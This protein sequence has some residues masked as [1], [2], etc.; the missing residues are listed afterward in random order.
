MTEEEYSNAFAVKCSIPV[1]DFQIWATVQAESVMYGL[2]IEFD[3]QVHNY[4][5]DTL[6][7]NIFIGRLLGWPPQAF[8]DDSLC[9]LLI[10]PDTTCL[11]SWDTVGTATRFFTFWLRDTLNQHLSFFNKWI[12]VIQ[13]RA[14]V[15]VSC[16]STHYRHNDT[17]NYEVEFET[18][19][20]G[21][22]SFSVCIYHEYAWNVYDTIFELR[23]TITYSRDSTVSYYSSLFLAQN[24]P[25]GNYRIISETFWRGKKAGTG[26][27][28]FNLAGP[29][30]ALTINKDKAI[31]GQ[32]TVSFIFSVDP[33]SYICENNKLVYY[34]SAWQHPVEDTLIMHEIQYDTL[35]N[36]DTLYAPFALDLD[37]ITLKTQQYFFRYGLSSLDTINGYYLFDH[38]FEL[39]MRG[40]F[41]WKRWADTVSWEIGLKNMGDFIT[42]VWLVTEF[43]KP[44]GNF[45]DSVQI[46]LALDTDT[47]IYCQTIID[48]GTPTGY[49]DVATRVWSGIDYKEIKRLCHIVEPLPPNILIT[50]DTSNY[51]VGDTVTVI[52]YNAGELEGDV[53][54][55]NIALYDLDWNSFPLDTARFLIS[56][57]DFAFYKFAVPEVMSGPYHLYIMGNVEIYNIPIEQRVD[58]GID[59]IEADITLLTTK[60]IY[61]PYEEVE[62]QAMCLNGNY[63]F[64]GSI[65]L[66]ITRYGLFPGDTT[67]A[68]GDEWVWRVDEWTS[69]GCTLSNNKVSLIG[70]DKLY[71]ADWWQL[72]PTEANG[73]ECSSQRVLLLKLLEAK[74]QGKGRGDEPIKYTAM[75][76]KDGELYMAMTTETRRKIAGPYPEWTQS[77]DLSEITSIYQFTMDD[78]Y[79]YITDVDS[80]YVYKV[81]RSSGSIEK[82]WRVSNPGGIGVLSGYL[83]T[84]DRVNHSVLKTNLSGDTILVFGT[85]S[86]AEPSDLAIDSL[87]KIYVADA[88]KARVY[89]FD[90]N[91][92]YLG[93]KGDGC[94]FS[95]IAVDKKGYLYGAD[96]D[97]M[98]VAKFDEN[99][100][101]V[102]Y[103][104]WGYP[105]EIM[106]CDTL[107]HLA[108]IYSG[109]F[110]YVAGN[111]LVNYGRNRGYSGTEFIYIPGLKYI[112]NFIA[113]DDPKSGA[114]EYYFSG[115][116]PNGIELPFMPID[117]L[118]YFDFETEYG[119]VVVRFRS[120]LS[121]P[122][123]GVSPEVEKLNFTY[124]SR[125]SGDIVWFDSESLSLAPL[126][127][128]LI[129]KNA[130]IISDSGEFA[131]WG[132]VC[133]ANGQNYPPVESH[134]FFIESALLSFALRIDKELY[135]PHEEITTSAIIVNNSD[136]TYT[137]IT[138]ELFKREHEVFDTL[139]SSIAPQSACTLSLVLSDSSS[140]LLTGLLF[141]PGLD[142]M[143][144]YKNVDI[145]IPEISFWSDYPCSVSHRSFEISTEL[146][147]W[148]QREVDIIFRSACG[149]SVYVDTISLQPNESRSIEHDFTI[150]QDES[151]FTEIIHP[152]LIKE[153]YPIRFGER[154][155][156]IIDSIVSSQNNIL[157][158]YET[159]NIG[160]FD[161]AFEMDLAITNT[162]GLVCD[163]MSCLNFLQ[164]DDSLQGEWGVSLDFGE[165][166]LNWTT[167]PESS[168]IILGQ[169]TTGI[170]IIQPNLVNVDS[171]VLQT[172]CDSIGD[173]LFDVHVKNNSANAFYGN[174]GLY[175]SFIGETR[176]LELAPFVSD[177]VRFTSSATLNKGFELVTAKIL[178]NGEA[179]SEYTDS[180]YF[181]SMLVIDSLPANLAFNIG[182]TARIC[183]KTE[184]N[185]TAVGEENLRFEFADFVDESRVV[186]LVPGE[187]R[188]DTFLFYLPE[189]LEEKTYYAS[190][191]LGSEEFV[192]PIYILGYKIIVNANLNQP[193]FLPGDTVIL[194]LN[195]ENQN[196]L[197]LKGF[198]V[199]N[200][201][202]ENLTQN[203]LLSGFIKNIDISNPEF[204]KATGDSGVYVSTILWPGNFDSLKITPQGSGTFGFYA[205]IVESD[206][207]HYSGWYDDSIITEQSQALQIKV[208]FSDT[209]ST[210]ERVDLRLFDSLTIRDTIIEQFYPVDL[211]HELFFLFEP[212][213]NLMFYGVYTESGRGLWLS[214]IHVFEANDTCNII[215]NNQVY[216]MG[217]TVYATVQSPFSGEL[218]WSSD[219]DPFGTIS[220]SLWIDS[221]SNQFEFI[222][223]G[224]LS[225]GQ[226]S[227]DFDFY[228]DGDTLQRFSATQSFD[229]RG[230]QVAVFDCRLDTNEYQVNDS[231]FIRFKLNSSKQIPLI[232]KL[233]FA[234]NY[235]WY[236]ALC[237]TIEVDSGYNV[238]DLAT[239]VVP[240]LERGPALLSYS[241]LK[242][243]IFLAYSSEGFMVYIPDSLAPIAQFV[244]I[245]ENTY[246]PNIDYT[247]R[248]VATDE[249]RIYDTL[250]YHN[251]ITQN[252][253]TYQTK[254]GDTLIYEIPSQPRGTNIAYYIVL[255]DS[256]GNLTRLPEIDYNQFWVLSP[257]PPSNCETDTINQNIE[258]SW[259]N[260]TENLIYHSG[261]PYEPKSDSI[262]VRFTPQYLPAELKAV[263]LFVEKTTPD[264]AAL[265]LGFYSVDQGIPGVELYPPQTIMVTEEGANWIDVPIDSGAIE[266]ELFVI[267]SGENIILYG[268]GT[269]NAYRTLIRDEIWTPDTSFGN[270]LAQAGFSY[271]PESTFYRV[272][273]E[274]TMQFIVIADSLTDKTFIDSTVS[275]ERRFRYLVQT[276]YIL[277]DLNGTSPILTQTYDYTSPIF[278][279]SITVVECASGYLVAC[280]IFDGIGVA[281][282]SLVYNGTPT[283]HDS[284]INDLYWYTVPIAGQTIAYYFTAEDSAG[285]TARN[286][287][288]GYFY[289]IP[290]IPE[291]FSGHISKDTTWAIDILIKGDVWVDSGVTLT[292][293][294]GVNVKFIPNIDDEHAGIDTTRAEFIIQGD[295]AL[296]GNDSTYVFFTS[297]VSQPEIGNWYGIRFENADSSI[298]LEYTEVE[299]AEIGLHCDLNKPFQVKYCKIEFCNTGVNSASK[300]TKITDSEF[301]NNQDGAVITDG[302]LNMVKRCD[303]INNLTALTI[304]GDREK[305][306]LS[307]YQNSKA[308]GEDIH[309]RIDPEYAVHV[310]DYRNKGQKVLVFDNLFSGNDTG[311]VFMDQAGA[312]VK[313]NEIIENLIGLFITDDACPNLG[314]AMSGENLFIARSDT[315]DS[316]KS[317]VV[318]NNTIND[319]LA[320][321]NWWGTNEEDSITAIIWDYYDDNMLGLVD[322]KPFRLSEASAAGGTSEQGGGTQSGSEVVIS[323]IWFE[324]AAIV[325]KNNVI[326]SYCV[327]AD[328]QV[329][330]EIYDITGRLAKRL[331][332]MKSFGPR[333]IN[334]NCED[335]AGGVYFVRFKA[336][337][338]L[339]IEKIV[340]L[341]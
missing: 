9:Q 91:G 288:T 19:Y 269:T 97:S 158:A 242:D 334:I 133:L 319:I 62:P 50:T 130:G 90:N 112:N 131:L 178:Q 228:I 302:K 309:Q 57:G 85:D 142:T 282:D 83:Y 159:I 31:T 219:F 52:L 314:K 225:S 5:A 75:A 185:G 81:L 88:N 337:D 229:V 210:L 152:V 286:P 279:D 255:E 176:V 273:R 192:L 272:M 148:W 40:H 94:R 299:Y 222:I 234:Q 59:G 169:G 53:K 150:S 93:A 118:P 321:G 316:L 317:Y 270:L 171:V 289:I 129:E 54:L 325:H 2:P 333:E 16:D 216:D 283:T 101:L 296:C 331:S 323:E 263:K 188:V 141:R 127:S 63:Q 164:I 293:N 135:Y 13:P 287:D 102:E 179:L 215:T 341:K 76:E 172:E 298:A 294:A 311:L 64:K 244:E 34:I 21:V 203:F 232:A 202:G 46:G 184:N 108:T 326:I 136:S 310:E 69:P 149:E 209:V 318:Y 125:R 99:G 227:I 33:P 205:R 153:S 246:N 165:Y 303:F 146:S 198:S 139:I 26:Y 78:N 138:L 208:Q 297:N 14:Q 186:S 67:L 72:E 338:Y 312:K 199:A 191:W 190:V 156:M 187:S 277:P 280:Q 98:K 3:I 1:G 66:S 61:L 7:G 251:G 307:S 197:N 174:I 4:T 300:F 157:I 236:D 276:H 264:T 315:L 73:G 10:L 126:D 166:V 22:D 329:S 109:Y 35:R 77:Y 107:I 327:P 96:M 60:D 250:Y 324:L 11:F 304:D 274:D 249:T 68:P 336:T 79:F 27:G 42:P 239:L 92:N 301:L 237:D 47:L 211:N 25:A 248:I 151:L 281:V 322:Y 193:N 105:D 256:F 252:K 119:T 24:L 8:Y 168:T 241:F 48:S 45:Y 6:L 295:L 71:Y 271:E 204:V 116:I 340:I 122:T 201:N 231:M 180:L 38:D 306:Q 189:D 163:S 144:Q 195:I 181:N 206:S 154:L 17:V 110:D 183:I 196:E 258:I 114:I 28:R 160:E 230:Y 268:D 224:E 175:A 265:N 320:Q 226:Y 305:K 220:D 43:E 29:H 12:S 74:K 137:D 200:Y 120:V 49:Y 240:D 155:A 162:V 238:I 84:V 292:I 214:T 80:E 134:N 221:L 124:L 177:T 95:Q 170:S 260:P 267:F 332:P 328:A 313:K 284:I 100:I 233:R 330:I 32:D 339:K 223:P 291:G 117:S 259:R 18:N 82:R 253:I 65:D 143:K 254:L 55:T 261:Y 335:L 167:M 275:G 308:S 213:A 111:V 217:D 278:G 290:H 243:S 37:S 15:S 23:D 132:D 41:Y 140:C 123:I 247:V 87:G 262:A 212:I 266:D 36:L 70:W 44:Q 56:G 86:L 39:G 58:L 182:D 235:Q 20:Q 161:C 89:I 128:V 106:A 257:L 147:N 30:I 115:G 218:V 173:L 285:N 113:T 103:W 207:V 145:Q 104:Y 245:P 51:S 121:K 194:N